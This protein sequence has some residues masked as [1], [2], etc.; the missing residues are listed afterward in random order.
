MP[1]PGRKDLSYLAAIDQIARKDIEIER[2][3]AALAEADHYVGCCPPPPEAI[4][5]L[6]ISLL[7]QRARIRQA[8]NQEA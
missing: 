1:W 2:L 7:E 6:R 5:D 8:A 4:G 3:R